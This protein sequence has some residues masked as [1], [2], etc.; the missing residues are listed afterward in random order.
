MLATISKSRK[1]IAIVKNR[2]FDANIGICV[3]IFMCWFFYV[4]VLDPKLHVDI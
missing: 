3:V 1:F 2:A 4:P